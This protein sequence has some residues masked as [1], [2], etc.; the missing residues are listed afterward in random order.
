V[1]A[2]RDVRADHYA[3]VLSTIV[4]RATSSKDVLDIFWAIGRAET[5]PPAP[6][7]RPEDRKAAIAAIRAHAAKAKNEWLDDLAKTI[8]A[9]AKRSARKPFSYAKEDLD[10]DALFLIV[11]GA[12]G[13]KTERELLVV[14]GR[15]AAF[16]CGAIPAMRERAIRAIHEH[17]AKPK[18]EELLGQ[19]AETLADGY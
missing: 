2:K 13:A 15:A 18:H 16:P 19:I 3:S 12:L 7:V 8:A 6:R 10:F 9:T 17:R 14:V 4:T 1:A 11:A 5:L